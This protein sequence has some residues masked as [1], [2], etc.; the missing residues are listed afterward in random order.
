MRWL[1]YP[2]A[3]W[4]REGYLDTVRARVNWTESLQIA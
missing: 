1:R 3:T 4:A 2:Q